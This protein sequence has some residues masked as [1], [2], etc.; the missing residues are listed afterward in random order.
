MPGTSSLEA[1]KIV[2]SN[3]L[4]LSPTSRQLRGKTS[5]ATMD[6][7]YELRSLGPATLGPGAL[8]NLVLATRR[9]S[10]PSAVLPTH[11]ARS[12]PSAAASSPSALSAPSTADL[13]KLIE[14]LTTTV[15]SLQMSVAELQKEKSAPSS[16]VSG[17]HDGQHHHDRPP[18]FQKLDFPRYDG[19]TDPLIFTHRYESY[20]HQRRIMEE[21][22]V[23][24]AS[25]NLEEGVQMWYIQVQMDEGTPSWHRFKELLNLRYG[26]PLRATPLTELAE[27]RCTGTVAK[28]QD[29]FQALLPRAGPLT[30][31]QRVQ[32]FTGGLQPPL[33]IDVRIQN[34]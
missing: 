7:G 21:E 17:G 32:L 23:W 29:R 20:F 4:S 31:A 22:K 33:S 12:P 9:S 34:P 2:I 24:M 25:Y 19:K 27:C 15:A 3:L 14:T 28:Y 13:V 18:R 26:P 1:S 5:L 10:S 8:D 11:S 16:G 6:C 30:E